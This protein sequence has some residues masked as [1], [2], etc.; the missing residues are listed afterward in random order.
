MKS[1]SF[2][3]GETQ[4]DP[5]QPNSSY[6]RPNRP[7]HSKPDIP[8]H[9]LLHCIGFGSYGE[10]W[11]ARNV[12]GVYRAVKVVYR[13]T[14]EKET[15]YHREFEGIKKFEP[16]S[17][18]HESQV[19][20]LHVGRNDSEGYFYYV[21]ELADDAG[22]K[23][24]G[25]TEKR[26]LE[27]DRYEPKTLRSEL[28]RQG[29]MPIETCL[30]LALG[31]TTALQHLHQ[32]GLVHRDIKPSN[33]II[34]NDIPKLADI[35]LVARAEATLSFVG[36][37]GYFP[38]EGPG[39]PQA[40]IYSL[41]KVLYE[42]ATGKDRLDF[43]EPPTM[44]QHHRDHDLFLEFN[45]V[46]LKACQAS[47]RDRYQSAAELHEDLLVL[48]AGKSL[49]RSRYLEKR[50]AQAKKVGTVFA[51]VGLLAIAGYLFQQQQTRQ[52]R[53]LA[54]E[55][56]ELALQETRQ[57]HKAEAAA[58]M[59]ELQR[60]NQMLEEG[61]TGRGLAMLASRVRRDPDDRFAV[62]RLLSTLTY[63]NFALP[64]AYC[65][66]GPGA[67]VVKSK[68]GPDSRFFT[69]AR[70]TGDLV[71]W[72]LE[73]GKQFGEKLSQVSLDLSNPQLISG[74]DFSR[75]GTRMVI[76]GGAISPAQVWSVSAQPRLLL[77]IERKGH[78]ISTRAR[79]SPDGRR[80]VTVHAGGKLVIWDAETGDDLVEISGEV[81]R[82]AGFPGNMEIGFSPGGR[83][84]LT[85]GPYM[86]DRAMRRF[87][88]W[89]AAT[90]ELVREFNQPSLERGRFRIQYALDPQHPRL[91]YFLSDAAGQIEI[92]NY[93]TGEIFRNSA[94][95]EF[96]VQCVAWHPNGFL[97]ASGGND[98]KIRIWEVRDSLRLRHVLHHAGLVRVLAFSPNGEL[99]ASGSSENTF[100][101]WNPNSG[102]PVGE[103]QLTG[104]IEAME[105]SPDGGKLLIKKRNRVT[106]WD[107]QPGVARPIL[108][109]QETHGD[110]P[111]YVTGVHFLPE[112]S[113]L[114]SSLC[115]SVSSGSTGVWELYGSFRTHHH[116]RVWDYQSAEPVSGKL[117]MIQSTPTVAISEAK[118]L[119]LV[120][121]DHGFVVWNLVEGEEV[122]RVDFL[123]FTPGDFSLSP[124]G[125]WALL[126]DDRHNKVVVWD[127]I[128][129]ELHTELEDGDRLVASA[130]SP[131]SERVFTVH[132]NGASRLREVATGNLLWEWNTEPS[133]GK[134]N[135]RRGPIHLEWDGEGRRV[136][137]AHYRQA[138]IL[139]AGSGL[140][141]IGPLKHDGII[142]S[143]H[144]NPDGRLL[145]TASQD[146]TAKI[147]QVAT[148]KQL[149]PN[150]SHDW[151]V[152]C[153]DFSEDS[154]Y[155]ATGSWDNTAKLWDRETGLPLSDPLH[156]LGWVTALDFHAKDP[157]LATASM[158]GMVRLWEF[159]KAAG[160]AP[161]WL[162]ELAENVGGYWLTSSKSMERI[163]EPN[164]LPAIRSRL[165]EES[166][167]SGDAYVRWGRWFFADR[168]RRTTSP[169]STIS[170]TEHLRHLAKQ[171]NRLGWS[172]STAP[173]ESLLRLAPTEP[174][175]LAGLAGCLVTQNLRNQ[176]PDY[177][178]ADWL[179]RLA[180]EMAPQ[181]AMTWRARAQV[182][183]SQE[184]TNEA[185]T[186]VQG[187][188]K[189]NPKSPNAWMT[190]A[191]IHARSG[192]ETEALQ[193]FREAWHNLKYDTNSDPRE[194]IFGRDPLLQI[195]AKE[196][197]GDLA[198][199]DAS[200]LRDWLNYCSREFHPEWKRLLGDWV[201][202]LALEI[203]PPDRAESV[204]QLRE[205]FLNQTG[206][207]RRVLKKVPHLAVVN[208]GERVELAVA[209]DTDEPVQF[210]WRHEKGHQTTTTENRL[211]LENPKPSDAGRYIVTVRGADP[212]S[213]ILDTSTPI[214]LHVA[215][216]NWVYGALQAET[217]EGY[218][219]S[220]DS[221]SLDNLGQPDG[222]EWLSEA[223]YHWNAPNTLVRISG[224]LIPPVTGEYRFFFLSDD[225]G[226][227]RLSVGASD[228]HPEVIAVET[229]WRN[230]R[231]WE[232]AAQGPEGQN[233]SKSIF[234][235]AG[236]PRYLEALVKNKEGQAYC[237][238]AWRM[239]GDPPL[240]NGD[241]P[242]PT[243][244]FAIPEPTP[245]RKVTS[246]LHG[247]KSL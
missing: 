20:I 166:A 163:A 178:R 127:V 15:P 25:V 182:L 155:I 169:S 244:F 64:G 10:V 115:Q 94:G 208:S 204:R 160:T 189:R 105:F 19:D 190:A 239:P 4:Y 188:L 134:W 112:R 202:Q 242:I 145:V 125:R 223:E 231:V 5:E 36:T 53:R 151:Q 148:G 139:D 207:A 130:F 80:I 34:V 58:R 206:M 131:D 191:L 117:P 173:Y 245:N 92:W 161:E 162:P 39:K 99:L 119:G 118:S 67:E 88:V 22:F 243:Q 1:D 174:R 18:S 9:E 27:L 183:L 132:G 143:M 246:N 95:H 104:E 205:Q 153:A 14:F 176:L 62:E 38:P 168:S 40:D 77:K 123:E 29:R 8:D 170:M 45:E 70:N 21:M 12:M 235:E 138:V 103:P 121:I 177:E 85:T 107:I 198:T 82:S 146:Q 11:L 126:G 13:D 46:I 157:W 159:P 217:W 181:L 87:F 209:V 42:M 55:N 150:L 158:D 214:L 26:S 171:A 219:Q 76:P 111:T 180:V 16:V 236:R 179:T 216:Q 28:A 78:G 192:R 109:V 102:R 124:D 17:R 31:L 51:S 184:K 228:D 240:E 200:F 247:G 56:R 83:R 233:V 43:P 75:D 232:E 90:G 164:K 147:W 187:A 241:P 37:E 63:R 137:L 141:M 89:D 68:V 81:H 201:A 50:L 52:A 35:G 91:A 135:W 114:L 224:W 149:T 48:R 175:V 218:W 152:Y 61:Q 47:V 120:K 7:M 210:T 225:A 230:P 113:R 234:L 212:H 73:T 30:D 133:L 203:A 165:L 110:R 199:A 65:Y 57:R 129:G 24:P 97:M 59:H 98:Q 96:P 222:T 221:P 197:G 32:N 211:V 74:M 144:F 3:Q 86:H 229:A 100:Q 238:I 136:A 71:V 116:A 195:L 44:V 215:D 33:I 237:G 60:I 186:A 227:L 172:K 142:L 128:H 213:R 49:K 66:A 6:I 69:M 220:L 2:E 79:F 72:D 84:I 23:E 106:I 122:L 185:E 41:G 156:H 154:Q 93:E 140:R 194:D 167:E 196:T 226:R 54:L 108:L 193:S 101:L